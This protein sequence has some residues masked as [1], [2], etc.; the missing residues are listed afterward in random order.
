MSGG[1]FDYQQYRINDIASAIEDDIYSNKN[2][3]S[4]E[5]IE[6]FE[7]A[8]KYLRIAEA[9]AQRIDWFMSGDE[10]EDS[11]NERWNETVQPLI[12][13]LNSKSHQ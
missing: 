1:H 6:K 8:V 5:M 10:A 9:M 3:F 7:L 13:G 4:K 2:E 11:F 12:D